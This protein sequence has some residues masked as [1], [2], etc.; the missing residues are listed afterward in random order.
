MGRRRLNRILPLPLRYKRT[1]ELRRRKKE[2]TLIS[3]REQQ[4]PKKRG[5]DSDRVKEDTPTALYGQRRLNPT[6]HAQENKLRRRQKKGTLIS[7]AF[8]QGTTSPEEE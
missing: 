1:R 3:L 4:V 2:G 6:H 7:F 8:T 5:E